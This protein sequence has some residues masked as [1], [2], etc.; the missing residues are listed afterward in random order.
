MNPA[1]AIVTFCVDR[2]VMMVLLVGMILKIDRLI[3]YW[4]AVIVMMIWLMMMRCHHR[5]ANSSIYPFP[6]MTLL[7]DISNSATLL[8]PEKNMGRACCRVYPA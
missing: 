7:P 2:A 4:I 1:E 8:R 3:E 6:S 5:G